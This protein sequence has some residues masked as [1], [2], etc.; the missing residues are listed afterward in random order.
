MHLGLTL[1]VVWACGMLLFGL[2]AWLFG[3]APNSTA[4]VSEWY[5]GFGPTAGGVAAGVVWGFV[6][7]FVSGLL[8]GWVYNWFQKCKKC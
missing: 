2:A 3:Y 5:R 1:G 6:D 4:L 7:G 8:I